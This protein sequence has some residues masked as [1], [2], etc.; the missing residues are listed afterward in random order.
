MKQLSTTYLTWIIFSRLPRK[1][2]NELI[3]IVFLSILCG[4]LEYGAIFSLG[5]LISLASGGSI[6]HAAI[7]EEL[8]NKFTSTLMRSEKLGIIGLVGFLAV[9]IGLASWLAKILNQW[10]TL[11]AINLSA[12]KLNGVLI[13]NMLTRERFKECEKDFAGSG[14]VLLYDTNRVHSFLTSISQ[15]F[16][17][18]LL[19]FFVA[20]SMIFFLSPPVIGIT[21]GTFV[22]YI[23]CVNQSK[24]YIQN[25]G[26]AA[27][28]NEKQML[29][30]ASRVG[31]NLRQILIENDV[32]S[33]SM[34]FQSKFFSLK[35]NF[36]NI[37][38]IT[39][40]PS[41]VGE[42]FLLFLIAALVVSQHPE[43]SSLSGSFSQILILVI[44]AQRIMPATQQVFAYWAAMQSNTPALHKILPL[45]MEKPCA[46]SGSKKILAFKSLKMENISFRYSDSGR[47]AI[48]NLNFEVKKGDKIALVG[49]SGAGKST[50]LDIL[51]LLLNPQTGSIIINQV[52]SSKISIQ[53]W[54]NKIS[55]IPQDVLLIGDT[56]GEAVTGKRILSTKEKETAREI[57]LR[58]DW[59]FQEGPGN[60]WGDLKIG[61]FGG[62]LSGGQRRKIAAARSLYERKEV[63]FLDEVTASLDPN[64]EKAVLR[65][66]LSR[67]DATVIIVSHQ[68]T[69]LQHCK[70]IIRLSGVSL[71]V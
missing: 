12:T 30:M 68:K 21:L 15:I 47:W 67:K 32:E 52:I 50:C 11:R 33:V 38:I 27:A 57:L 34:Q 31:R 55:Y 25:A 7:L 48:A 42:F 69:T 24:A 18:G 14:S 9:G 56:L 23:I 1:C 70:K 51:A 5:A 39:M 65:A 64:S 2:K 6:A 8:A 62:S 22:L 20:A 35:Q 19:L 16:S 71:S 4:I 61:E 13:K 29:K 54:W 43:S 3:G 37:Q 36:G 40:L 60:D 10:L 66:F 41:R 46:N 26:Q 59:N 49:P 58:L 28:I 45:L 17:N 63:V 44:A 53:D